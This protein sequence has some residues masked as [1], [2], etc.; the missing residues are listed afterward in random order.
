MKQELQA[1]VNIQ[2]W[3]TSSITAMV[4]LWPQMKAPTTMVMTPQM[5]KIN[6]Q[7]IGDGDDGQDVDV[8]ITLQDVTS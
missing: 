4:V 6:L 8:N 7:K 5:I 3:W 1:G 2:N